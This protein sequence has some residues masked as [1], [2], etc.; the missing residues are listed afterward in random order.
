M[1]ADQWL[2]SAMLDFIKS[3]LPVYIIKKNFNLSATKTS[4]LFFFEKYINMYYQLEAVKLINL[5]LIVSHQFHFLYKKVDD[6][7]VRV[8]QS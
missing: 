6:C 2:I 7:S 4:P 5:K 8:F 1:Y 3:A